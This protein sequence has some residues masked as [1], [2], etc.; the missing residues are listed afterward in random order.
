MKMNVSKIKKGLAVALLAMTSLGASAQFTKH[1]S[2]LNTS[3]T[4]LNLSYGKDQKVT[5][6]MQAT[7]GYFLED[8]WMIYGR[9]GYDH[10]F[11]KDAPDVN[12]VKVGVG[13]R[14]YIV[15]NGLYLNLGMQFEH[16][17]PNFN[18]LQMTPEVG[19]CFYV[20]QFLSI[21]PAVYSDICLNKFSDGST[22][23]LKIGLGFYF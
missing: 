12:N 3:L 7:G 2:Y 8:G 19:Y 14:Y 10:Q 21:E 22:V 9:L 4:G 6:G 15:Q 18:Y 20:N 5:F 16:R 13:G 23:G 17:A 1:T 11:V